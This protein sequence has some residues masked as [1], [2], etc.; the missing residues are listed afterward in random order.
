MN[1]QLTS[2]QE[3]MS[4]LAAEID[5][6]INNSLPDGNGGD[7]FLI[8]VILIAIVG[9]LALANAVRLFRMWRKPS[10]RQ[11]KRN[12]EDAE[13]P[14]RVPIEALRSDRESLNAERGSQAE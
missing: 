11:P 8:S 13:E 3:A 4:V 12:C 10:R 14:E 2:L 6:L 7:T 9:A 1:Q 5:D